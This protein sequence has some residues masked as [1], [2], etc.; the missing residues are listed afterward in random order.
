MNKTSVYFDDADT[1]RLHRLAEQEGTSYADILRAALRAYEAQK[2][3]RRFSMFNS[4]EG[5]G[6]SV[7]DI[8]EDELMAGFGED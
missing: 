8:P 2:G 5:D 3:R 4:G 7:A 6:R 1:A